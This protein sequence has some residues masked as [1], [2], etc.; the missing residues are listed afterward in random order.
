MS[1]RCGRCGMPKE[2]TIHMTDNTNIEIRMAAHTFESD[3]YV[4][5]LRYVRAGERTRIEV[6]DSN[7]ERAFKVYR[8]KSD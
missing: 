3:D 5:W 7:A 2:S 6:C 8:R 4:A 1:E